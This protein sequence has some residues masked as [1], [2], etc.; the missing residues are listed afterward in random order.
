MVGVCSDEGSEYIYLVEMNVA[1]Q[2]D[3]IGIDADGMLR[4]ERAEVHE[5]GFS[6][7]QI[8]SQEQLSDAFTEM[9]AAGFDVTLEKLHDYRIQ[10]TPLDVLTD[11]QHEV[12]EVAYELGYY[13][14]PRRSSTEE[15]AAELGV[16]DS[17]VSE[18]LQ[19]AE[20]NLLTNLLS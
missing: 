1:E 18:H 19:R 16:D 14:V 3:A 10:K 5:Q 8:G 13:D 20:R 4:T 12:L 7:D 17:T 11:R 2:L 15:V 6:V 9:Q